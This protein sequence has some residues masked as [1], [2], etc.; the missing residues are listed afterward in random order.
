MPSIDS[1]TADD[2]L[3]VV[4]RFGAMMLRAGDTAFRVRQAMDQLAPRLG[5][6]RLALHISLGSITATAWRQGHATTLTT[7]I[8][9]PG[10]DA[11]RIAAL[12][13]IAG[14]GRDPLTP[15]DLAVDL[16]RLAAAKPLHSVATV[17]VAIGLASAAF[18]YLNGGD[19]LGTLAAMVA[20]AAG[21]TT[22][23][24]L[25][26]RRLNQYAVSAFAA[27]LASGLYCLIVFAIAG[28][29]FSTA[30]A[31]GFISSALFLVPGFP[32]VAALLDL[33]QHQITAGIA[34]FFYALMIL[35]AAAFGLSVAAGI[36][37]L[38]A[39]PAPS[40]GHGIEAMSLVWRA[41][42]SFAGGCGFALL[43]NSRPGTV[44]AVGLLSL[45]GNELRLALHDLGMGL[46]PATFLGALTVG[47]LASVARARLHDPRIALT[48]PGIIIMTPGIYAFRTI[49]L[50]NQGEVLA[51]VE[52]G[53][54]CA[55]VVGAMAL[56]LAAARFA[57]ERHWMVER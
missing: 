48:V 25:F 49:V 51:A 54:V 15:G 46:P 12:E 7:E 37:N 43:Y 5:I 19:L 31:V 16:D 36:A 21:Q 53:A 34:R 47:L 33:V 30:H 45:A 57:T 2:A 41:L 11:A 13:A 20:G 14:D 55:F 1:E 29:G 28:R 56:G 38:P 26:R 27:L 35:L 42:A 39:V 24:L 9:P 18:S 3:A 6:E 17:A 23:A 22:R 10:I 40:P 44:L 52:A 8:A 32:L 4:L 50:L